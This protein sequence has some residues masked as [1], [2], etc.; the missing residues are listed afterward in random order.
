[1]LKIR[2]QEQLC[3]YQSKDKDA[4]LLYVRCI[5][6]KSFVL[7]CR[8]GGRADV[9]RPEEDEQWR[10]PQQQRFQAIEPRNQAMIRYH[11]NYSNEHFN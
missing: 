8:Y 11:S 5:A 2:L 4:E 3:L 1:M 9:A 10:R 7:F 6:I